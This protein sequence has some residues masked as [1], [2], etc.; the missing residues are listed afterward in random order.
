MVR[1]LFNYKNQHEGT[2]VDIKSDGLAEVLK[3][4]N[5]DVDGLGLNKTPPSA[6]PILFF[7]SR[8]SLADRLEDEKNK[9]VPD[10]ILVADLETALQFT[11][12][13]HAQAIAD[14]DTLLAAEECTWELLPLLYRPSS[15]VYHYHKYTQQDQILRFKRMQKKKRPDSTPYWEFECDVVADSGVRFGLGRYPELLEIDKFSGARKIKD[16]I[17]QPLKNTGREE[18]LRESLKERGK[19]YADLRGATYWYVLFSPLVQGIRE[20]ELL[21]HVLRASWLLRS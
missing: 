4:C 8:F 17:I 16:L 12:D 15:L 14:M 11:H 18:Q 1:R 5:V 7:H 3:E 20:A 21:R 19:K 9:K 13:E 6:D 2:K 10:E